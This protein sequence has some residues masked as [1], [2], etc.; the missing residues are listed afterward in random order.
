M[1]HLIKRIGPGSKRSLNHGLQ[2][3]VRDYS[4]SGR[5]QRIEVPIGG[6]GSI[7]LDI[8]P[9]AIGGIENSRILISLLPGPLLA[10]ND[11]SSRT[12]RTELQAIDPSTTLINLNYRLSNPFRKDPKDKFV[13]P[14]PIHDC[15]IAFSHILT[16]VIPNLFP[17]QH[18]LKTWGPLGRPRIGL[19]GTHIGASLATMLTLTNFNNVDAV[20][21][22]DPMVDWVMLDE[23]ISNSHQAITS[24]SR[25]KRS[26]ISATSPDEEVMSAAG[27]LIN[28]RTKL[29]ATPSAYFDAF[30]SPTLFLRA[31]GRDAPRTHAE[32]L[33][34]LDQEGETVEDTGADS[35][36]W[37]TIGGA[38]EYSSTLPIPPLEPKDISTTETDQ[39]TITEAI[40]TDS[41]GPYDD[42]MPPVSLR[43]ALAAPASTPSTT[44][45]KA[46]AISSTPPSSDTSDI[47]PSL[48]ASS[49]APSPST[50]D[51]TPSSPA[52]SAPSPDIPPPKTPT[53]RRK[54][55]RRWPPNGPVDTML[56]YFN[57]YISPPPQ[58]DSTSSTERGIHAITSMQARELVDLLRRACFYGREKGVGKERVNLVDMRK[59]DA[60]RLKQ[61]AKGRSEM[62][63]E[64]GRD[65]ESEVMRRRMVCWLEGRL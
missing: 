3:L 26:G 39:D 55:L 43:S 13:Y 35:D 32:A 17:G 11:A 29:F 1:I 7:N 19:M 24:P 59:G 34:L 4:S 64:E 33:G 5:V 63:G 25:G 2:S 28:M 62:M 16:D 22:A 45:Q 56:P 21:I 20:A 50:I 36:G 57:I 18:P 10:D 44:A 8:T 40:G 48:A 9:A 65:R 15:S 46:S 49:T 37:E 14:Q 53:K 38:D 27:H 47:P 60:D 41:F 12:F 31:P 23:V 61:E 54:V 42:D 58:L 6:N 52:Q 30:A 51:T